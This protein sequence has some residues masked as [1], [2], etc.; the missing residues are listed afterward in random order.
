MMS[1][2]GNDAGIEINRWS[3]LY[4]QEVDIAKLP[5]SEGWQSVYLPAMFQLPYSPKKS[6]QHVWFRGEF[7]VGDDPSRF[8]GIMPG[9]I[10]FTDSFYLNGVLIG[11]YSPDHINNMHYTRAYRIPA[12]LLRK[13]TNVVHIRVGLYGKEYGGIRGNVLVLPRRE[14][15]LQAAKTEFLFRQLP[16]GVAVFLFGQMMFNLLFFAWRRSEKANLYSAL[17]CFAWIL[18]IF[19]IFSP[20]TPFGPDVRIMFLWSCLAFV[21]IIFIMLIQAFY[22]VYVPEVNRIAIPVLL[23]LTAGMYA[24]PDTTSPYFL[25][26]KLGVLTLFIVTP[27]LAWLIWRVNTIKPRKTVLIFIFFGIFPGLFIVW[28]VINYLWVFHEPPIVHTYTLPIFIVGIMLLIIQDVMERDV[29]LEALY[30]ELSRPKEEGRKTVVTS[31]TEEKLERVLEFLR[32]NYT[33]DISREGLAAAIG[34]SGDHM[35]RMFKAYTGK[36]INDYINELRVEA[37]A[38]KLRTTDEKIIDIAFSV[39]FESLATF[40]RAFLK[41][42][43]VS[44]SNYRKD[45][46]EG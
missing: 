26:R 7:E 22:K 14:F 18:Y 8:Y 11:E 44:P 29:K 2:S 39:G 32:E 36:K 25:G 16:I 30:S 21:P 9:R 10:Y 40:N 3:L 13:G 41:V 33:S 1:C 5:Q 12:G 45:A 38:E 43:G 17:L 24:V 31:L 4:S 42:K 35:S 27:F 6:F 19:A 46:E 34:M 37:A 15:A 23:L 28:D 20:Y